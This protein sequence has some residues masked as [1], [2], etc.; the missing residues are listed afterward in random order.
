MKALL[1]CVVVG[2][3]Y[4]GSNVSNDAGMQDASADM[5]PINYGDL[6]CHITNNYT[7]SSLYDNNVYECSLDSGP[8]YSNIPW[9][10]ITGRGVVPCSDP[11]CV[12]GSAC[13]GENGSG[14]VV[15]C[16]GD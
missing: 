12:V 2:C 13:Q 3:A 14:V 10:C 7:D 6:C 11:N 4:S 8:Q 1:F 9:V 15:D 5:L 16:F